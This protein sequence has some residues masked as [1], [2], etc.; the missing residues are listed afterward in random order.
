MNGSVTT[1]EADFKLLQKVKVLLKSISYEK[2]QQ[3]GS[4]DISVCPQHFSPRL[5]LYQ[6]GK[7]ERGMIY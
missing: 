5:C 1:L 2:L 6:Y 4:F 7:G 3:S